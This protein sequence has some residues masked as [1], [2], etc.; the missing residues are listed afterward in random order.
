MPLLKSNSLDYS[1][2]KL[3]P[4][5]TLVSLLH[6][7]AQYQPDGQA[8]IFLR[9]GETES[10]SLTYG[11]LDRQAREIAAELQSWQG[12]RA[13]L[14]YSSGLEFI[15]AFFGCLYAGVVAVPAYPP[16]R[17]QKLSRLLSIANDAQAKL[18][19]TTTSILADIDR[20]WEQESELLAKLKWLATDTI[21]A[22]R[23][24]FV[25]KSL[26]PE[27]LAF[28]QYTSGSTG[29][30]K[31]VMVTHGNII[32]NQ[33]LIHQAFG[34]S[35]Q[36]IGVGWLPLFHDMGLIGH[37]FQPIY[38]GFPSIL[39]PP[40]AFLQRPIRW[41]KA[42]SQY[43]ATTSGGPNFAYDLCVTKVCPEQLA[44]LDLSSW[45]L[46]YSGAEPV[47]A[48]TLAQFRKKFAH[49][50]FNYN[51][52]YPCYGMAETTLFTTGGD[53]HQK[54]VIQGVKAGELEQNSVV[55]SEISSPE[56]C[57]FVGCGRSYLNTTVIIVNPESLT[58]CKKGQVGEIWVSGRS[59]ASG[60]W[61]R[62]EATQETF[63]AYLKDA[64]EGPFLRTGDLGFLLDGELFVTGRI[65]DVI[66]I[67]GQNYYPQDIEMTVQKS[68]PAL[69]PNCGAVFTAEFKGSERLVVVQEIE[70]SYLRKLDVNE[71]VGNIR[72]AV[73]AE[74]SLQVYAIV[75][76]KTG[77][78][79]KTSSGKIRRHACRAEFLTGSLNAV[80][81]WS[82]NPIAKAHFRHLQADV[83]SLLQ[84]LQ[85]CKQ[86]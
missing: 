28:L 13:L 75:L 41:L 38:V 51:A 50:G 24:E 16:R 17:N 44:N 84:K 31:G 78:I 39:M 12:E 47:R 43:R 61:N 40:V 3:E 83:E 22:N 65:K 45:D 15:T 64:Q 37:V 21:E 79:P 66:I 26:T 30:P 2:D 25:H 62:P 49:C 4:R 34:H 53:K 42:I 82:Q 70:R 6:Y 52:F 29:T 68:H 81:D 36:S 10:G 59:I 1:N 85:T 74:H 55:E 77:S 19:L 23:G 14:L 80:G 9:N 56:S 7:R 33:Q 57:L 8:Y 11:E 48:E 58:R 67:R 35:E 27:S 54:P 20:R 76:V 63:Q 69:R 86:L 32:H 5:S 71:V 73:T 46:A 18:A 72:Q 60:Y